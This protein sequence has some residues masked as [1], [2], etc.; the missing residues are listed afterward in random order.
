MTFSVN[1][2]PHNGKAG[3]KLTSQQIGQRL[4]QELESNV[5]INVMN[6]KD[7]NEEYE[8]QGRGEMQLGVLIENMRREGFEL[9]VSPPR[10]V[11]KEIEGK[12]MEPM[13]EVVVEVEEKYTG[14]VIQKVRANKQTKQ[15]WPYE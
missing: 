15:E 13:E 7:R 14:E 1:D 11:I 5:S 10:V 6:S 2:S 12:K 4:R 9:S 3:S 8:V